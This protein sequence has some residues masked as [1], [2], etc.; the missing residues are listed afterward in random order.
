MAEHQKHLYMIVFP[1]N[2]LVSSQLPPREFAQHYTIGSPRHF[3]GKVIF[4]EV[5]IAF[6]EPYFPIDEYLEKTVPH[7]DGSPK[8]T[9][10]I[11]SYGVLEHVSFN[12]MRSLYL[13]TTNGHALEL[14]A[15]PYT[16]ENAPGVIRIYQELTPITNLIASRLDQ[17]SFGRYI[18]TESRAKGAPKVCFTQITLN[19]E[20]FLAAS[21]KSNIISSP[22]P[23]YNPYRLLDCLSELEKDPSK[24]VK[25][26]SL[27][28]VLHNV[29]YR[30][31]RHGFWFFAENGEMLFYGMPSIHDLEDK[32]Y[33]WW[34]YVD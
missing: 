9:K 11:S 28:T 12:A 14:T 10:F 3:E 29:S 23:E 1:I 25:T 21:R 24:L 8:R 13:V 19:I 20:E 31:L 7:E 4:A 5:D 30:Q 6:R 15:Q 27:S 22:I 33:D 26:I 17:R 18:T 2:A 16:A 32:Y 34:K